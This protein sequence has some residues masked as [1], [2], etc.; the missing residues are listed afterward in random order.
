MDKCII[1]IGMPCSGKSTVAKACA[2][3]LGYTYISSGDIAREIAAKDKSA[4]E[5][6]DKGNMADEHLMRQR[7]YFKL[8][9]STN[10]VLDGFPRFID[11][12][13]WLHNLFISR[14][15]QFRYIYFPIERD[16]A[17]ARA[18]NRNRP[19]DHSIESR[20]DYYN[21]NTAPILTLH[22]HN[23]VDQYTD[24]NFMVRDTMSILSDR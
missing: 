6:L 5:S 23:V 9:L 20:I 21:T 16:E 7:I 2:K 24:I 11:Q 22:K 10:V 4:T 3:K 1:F 13:N 8:L 15:V 12:D 17:I 14:D 19:D 18:I